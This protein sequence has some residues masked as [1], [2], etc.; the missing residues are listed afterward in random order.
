[1]RYETIKDYISIFLFAS[2]T[3]TAYTTCQIGC[4]EDKFGRC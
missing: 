4:N 3:G 2:R 1:L